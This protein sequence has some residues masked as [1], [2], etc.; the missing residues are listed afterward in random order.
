MSTNFSEQAPFL[1]TSRAFPEDASQLPIE[2]TRAYIDIAGKVNNRTIG[3]FAVNNPSITGE[4]WFLT[5]QKQQTFRQVYPING[6]GSFPHGIANYSSVQ[7]TRI[8]G[9]FT[10]DSTAP[11]GPFWYTLPWVSVTSSTNQINIFLNNQFIQVTG[12]GG[13]A[14]PTISRGFVVLEWLSQP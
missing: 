1:R 10:D 13:G 5:S 2:L 4:S 9:T 8:Y 7:F 11:S 3:I 12:G 14:Q 6:T